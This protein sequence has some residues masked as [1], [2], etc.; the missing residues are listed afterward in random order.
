MKEITIT[1]WAQDKHCQHKVTVE[2]S[3]VVNTPAFQYFA[4][5]NRMEGRPDIRELEM[6]KFILTMLASK[7][8]QNPPVCTIRQACQVA[9]KCLPVLLKKIKDKDITVTMKI[10]VGVNK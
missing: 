9:N 2:P 6:T 5:V 8:Y 4:G 3:V 10:K 7:S 1:I